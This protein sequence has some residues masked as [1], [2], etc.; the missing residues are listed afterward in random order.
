MFVKKRITNHKYK[1]EGKKDGKVQWKNIQVTEEEI[2][3]EIEKDNVES[4]V[5][6]EEEEDINITGGR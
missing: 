5:S 4:I 3:A 1:R 6:E 2:T